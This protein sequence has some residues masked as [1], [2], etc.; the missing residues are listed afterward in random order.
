MIKSTKPEDFKEN[1]W[2]PTSEDP[3]DPQHHTP[4]QKRIL[5][6]L[7]NLQELERFNPQDNLESRQRFLSNFDWT[8]PMLKPAEIARTEDLLVEFHNIFARHR[9]DIGMNEDFKVELTPKDDSPAYSQNL[10]T[11]I[12]LKEDIFVDVALVHRYGIIKT[13]PFSKYAIPIFAQEKPNGKLRLLVDSRKINNLFSV[14]YIN[15]NHPVSTLTCA[16]QH[17]AGKKL[18][19]TLDCSQAYHCLQMADQ[20]SIEMLVFN[21]ASRSLHTEDMHKDLAKPYRPFLVSCVKIW[22]KS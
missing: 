2:F 3:G 22:T 6:E 5:S 4:I 16:A 8:D 18:F 1:Y 11:P 7:I 19:R 20:R 12:N 13:L 15:N 21:F 14:Y 10:P 9:F 17:M